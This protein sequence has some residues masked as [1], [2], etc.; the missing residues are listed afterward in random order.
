M[1]AGKQ[2]QNA[3]HIDSEK[4][5]QQPP[6]SYMPLTPEPSPIIP[7]NGNPGQQSQSGYFVAR[8][9][10]QLFQQTTNTQF[11]SAQH[12]PPSPGLTPP[13]ATSPSADIE[14]SNYAKRFVGNTLAGRVVRASIQSVESAVI[15]PAY[16]S[17]WGDN[18]PFT[19]PNVRKRDAVLA[20]GAHVGLVGLESLAPS[21]LDVGN[22]LT[23]EL[24]NFGI[25]Q[26]AE[27]S[28][29]EGFDHVPKA[30][31]STKYVRSAHVKSVQARIKHKLM[32]VDANISFWRETPTKHYTSHDKGWF[33]PYLYSSGRTPSI[34][35]SQDFAVASVLGPGLRA[36]AAI[37]PMLLSILDLDTPVTSFCNPGP[38]HNI[39]CHRMLVLFLG[40]SPWRTHAWS[41]ARNPGEARFT[42]HLLHGVPALVL[43]VTAQAPICAWSSRTL[44]QMHEHSYNAAA[45]CEELFS[46]LET[47]VSVGDVSESIGDRYRGMLRSGLSP[48]VGA[49]ERTKG[50][51]KEIE[52]VVDLRR[53][54]VVMFRY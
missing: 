36:D 12:F 9:K 43:P 47:I 53:A 14:K 5:H 11:L 31:K 37:A 16:L 41:Q 48:M 7:H 45:H 8:P 32:G 28:L 13:A 23:T 33:C 27:Q 44:C 26:F 54:G 39:N 25:T 51:A 52:S 50:V 22:E 3:F 21:L 46:F 17:P 38:A 19:L 15:L 34:P 29:D 49:A 35:R 2:Q 24:V 40:I 6:P 1:S 18:N 30:G 10:Y 42:I 4:T 20:V